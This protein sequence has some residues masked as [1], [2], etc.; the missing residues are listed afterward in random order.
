MHITKESG[1]FN[2]D[3]SDSV[4]LNNGKIINIQADFDFDGKFAPSEGYVFNPNTMVL[5]H[6]LSPIGKKKVAF[7]VE[8]DQGG[9][10]LVVKE[11]E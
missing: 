8:D 7:K 1:E 10:K 3:F 4:S 11:V 6:R 2:F 9:E 5:K